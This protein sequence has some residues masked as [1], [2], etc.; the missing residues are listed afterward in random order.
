MSDLPRL[1]IG[2]YALLLALAETGGVL[3][4]AD[5]LGLTQ[6][7]A[8][9][10]LREA[11]RRLGIALTERRGRRLVPSP[12]AEVLLAPAGA[13]LGELA[14]AERRALERF[15]AGRRAVRVGQSPYSRYHWLPAFLEI[16]AGQHPEIEVDVA[17]RAAAEPLG[18]LRAGIADLVM[19]Y[20][21]AGTAGDLTWLH[22]GSDPL[23]VVMAPDHR[24]AGLPVVTAAD[25]RDERYITYSNRPE[26]GFEWEAVMRP[27]GIAPHRISVIE[28]PE[29]I[30]D[31]VRAGFG[32]S[33]LSRWAVSPELADGTL[34]ARPLAIDAR[35]AAGVELDWW[36]VLRTADFEEAEG[37]VRAVALALQ[38][39]S[40][41]HGVGL[42]V[43]AFGE[44]PGGR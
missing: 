23:V 4:A 32:V 17:V 24:L 29:A 14:R 13:A 15:G 16:L 5:R 12:A 33:A 20:G 9:H 27:A 6:S 41:L 22:L 21:Q 37:A 42:D 2:H 7:A 25:L 19:V 30:V 10:R 39:T 8:S 31:L 38:A 44:S 43:Q 11:E 34:A 18:A 35:Q 28:L 40:S 3:A 26:P 36:A 1:G